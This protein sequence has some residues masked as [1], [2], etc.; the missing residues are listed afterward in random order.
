M[1]AIVQDGYG[2][3][4]VLA[5]RDVP[6][7]AAGDGDVLVR[8]VAAGVDR[9]ALHFMTGRPYLMRLGTG[10]RSPKVVV[11][12]VSFAGRVESVGS[13]VTRFRAG[14]EVYGAARGS[15][16]EYVA[17]PAGKVALKPARLTFE[18]AAVLPY[19]SFA[20][21]QAV[22][23]HGKVKPGD[24]VLVVGASGAVGSIAVQLAKTFGAEVTGVCGT[25]GLDL[26]R[27]LGADHVIDYSREDFADGSRHYDVILD[28]FGRTP[29]RRLRR[30]LTPRGRLVIVGGEGDRWIGGIQRQ[31]AATVLSPFTRQDLRTFIAKENAETLETINELVD[32][33]KVAP[34]LDRSYPLD[35]ARDAVQRLEAGSGSGRL[36]L[37]V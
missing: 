10:M 11:P 12:G 23:D 7:P 16:A 30:A 29:L 5:V 26:A 33:G 31:L 18:Q 4:S 37:T 2:G 36:A 8:V 21:L 17:A 1:R 19:A 22:R 25:R 15:Y 34:V 27:S 35:E 24:H 20:A 6:I 14:D 28:V 9:G 3:A 13:G 32:A